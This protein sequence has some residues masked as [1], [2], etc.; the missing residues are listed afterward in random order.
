[1]M[2]V[3]LRASFRRITRSLVCRVQIQAHGRLVEPPAPSDRAPGRGRSRMR[4]ASPDDISSTL[5]SD[6]CDTSSRSSTSSAFLPHRRR[7]LVIRQIPMLEKKPDSTTSRP[8]KSRAQDWHQVVAH[9][10]Q[11][12]PQLKIFPA[13]PAENAQPSAVRRVARIALPA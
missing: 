5:R 3:P 11:H 4:R 2:L 13:V 8:E 6:R 12:H 7:D 1:M 10:P 9:D